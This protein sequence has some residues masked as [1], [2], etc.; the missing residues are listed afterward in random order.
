MLFKIHL[1]RKISCVCISTE[2]NLTLTLSLELVLK[3]CP[4]GKAIP[5][6]AVT[7]H[8]HVFHSKNQVILRAA[9]PILVFIMHRTARQGPCH[10]ANYQL[11]NL[12][13]P[14]I[15]VSKK[16]PLPLCQPHVKMHKCI[17]PMFWHRPIVQPSSF[18]LTEGY[19]TSRFM[20]C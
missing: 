1:V 15:P 9:R 6:P 20:G 18:C 16:S 13:S 11:C 5:E 3:K 4:G 8:L 2:V 17:K 10:T 12:C 19:H 14:K 7:G